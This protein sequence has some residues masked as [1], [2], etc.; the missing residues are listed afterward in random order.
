MS[1]KGKFRPTTSL[2]RQRGEVDVQLQS[3]RNPALQ[4]VSQHHAS[5]TITGPAN[6]PVDK[7]LTYIHSF[8]FLKLD[9][10]LFMEV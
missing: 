4:G 9:R 2:G 8:H 6:S 10:C 7:N 3:L 5:V 1:E